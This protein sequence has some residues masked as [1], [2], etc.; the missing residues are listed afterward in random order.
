MASVQD[1]LALQ[2]TPASPQQQ[3]KVDQHVARGLQ[4]LRNAGVADPLWLEIVE[5]HRLV[6]PEGPYAALPPG[7]KLG[8]LLERADR[9]ASQLACAKSRPA[10]AAAEAVKAAFRQARQQGIDEAGA[11][12]VKAT[13]VYPPGS[14]VRLVSGEIGLVLQRGVDATSPKVAVLISRS[15]TPLGDVVVRDTR[16]RPHDVAASV[17]PHEVRVR[18]NMGKLVQLVR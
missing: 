8:R 16:R 14:Y 12:V 1:Q 3:A 10:P 9:F 11:L 18:L 5:W 15:G 17:A 2:D 13:G 7:W 6:P 4:C